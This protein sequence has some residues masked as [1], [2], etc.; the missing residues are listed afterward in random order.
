MDPF[1]FDGDAG[2]LSMNVQ[3]TDSDGVKCIKII[4][5]YSA[6][7]C[8]SLSALFGT[9][10]RAM[11]RNVALIKGIGTK[12]AALL[13]KRGTRTLHDLLHGKRKAWRADAARLVPLIEARRFDVLRGE[14]R[15]RD[16]DLLYCFKPENVVYV[17]I[18][19]TG[20]KD[21]IAFL[22]A[23][24]RVDVQRKAIIITQFL[25]RNHRE[26]Y[27]VI[28]SILKYLK[29]ADCLVSFNGKGFDMPVLDDRSWYFH[30]E[31]VSSLVSH[32][33]DL[34]TD[35]RKVFHVKRTGGLGRIERG[36]LGIHR[37]VDIPS[38]LIPSIFDGYAASGRQDALVHVLSELATR[39]AL[40][41]PVEPECLNMLKVIWHNMVDVKSLHDLLVFTLKR[42]R[43]EHQPSTNSL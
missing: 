13:H 25:A 11:F 43:V 18:E 21:A 28:S 33:V 27:S 37:A 36:M 10:K 7:E 2:F 32:H 17:D 22:V 41:S 31:T 30:N 9:T 24:G 19:T 23:L 3:E 29:P 34:L 1:T 20:L 8:S 35:V 26:E 5:E 12:T 39:G 4:H 14:Q 6:R 40:H 42:L 15:T 38:C 16:I